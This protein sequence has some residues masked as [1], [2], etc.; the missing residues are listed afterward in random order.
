MAFLTALGNAAGGYQQGGQQKFLNDEDKQRLRQ[1][2]EARRAQEADNAARLGLDQTRLTDEEKHA[3]I[4]DAYTG[5]ETAALTTQNTQD[6]KNA[7]LRAKLR[8]PPGFDKM[9]PDQKSAYLY[10]RWT[11][12]QQTGDTDLATQTLNAIRDL[13]GLTKAGIAAT[14][15]GQLTP[16]QAWEIAHGGAPGS[17]NRGQL[18][19]YEK[20]EIAHGG[21]PGSGNKQANAEAV[22]Q[23]KLAGDYYND[24]NQLWKNMTT[25][26]IRPGIG[27]P[28]LDPA[29]RKPMQPTLAAD[30][31]AHA[32][33]D[34]ATLDQSS[35][36]QKDVEKLLKGVTN[37]A[38]VQML[39][40]YAKYRQAK[41]RAEHLTENQQAGGSDANGYPPLPPG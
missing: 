3:A 9:D 13:S 2:Q 11:I 24:F 1:E 7:A 39:T 32:R 25:V 35:D 23:G 38:Y 27:L 14:S 22:R 21:A 15:R 5:A 18:T 16:F 29:T 37:K 33:Q 31:Q 4:A 30:Q 10:N 36:P 41:M 40:A 12:A 19:E 26:P 20:W 6:A 34:M 28:A 17:D 8:L